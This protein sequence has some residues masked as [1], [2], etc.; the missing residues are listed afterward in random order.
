MERWSAEKKVY[1][2]VDCSVGKMGLKSVDLM[3]VR[4]ELLSAVRS[5]VS[6]VAPKVR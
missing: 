5:V 2:K 4:S 3:A 6:R 1:L